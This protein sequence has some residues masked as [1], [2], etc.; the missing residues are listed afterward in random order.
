M[1]QKETQD[2]IDNSYRERALKVS[3][4]EKG[5]GDWTVDGSGN[6]VSVDKSK[7]M[8]VGGNQYNFDYS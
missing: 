4:Y 3:M 1:K 8:N 7:I 6:V 2:A 5:I